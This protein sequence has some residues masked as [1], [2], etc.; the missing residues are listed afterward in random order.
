MGRW[1]EGVWVISPTVR[2]T[3]WGLM[4]VDGQRLGVRREAFDLLRH[5]EQQA[6]DHGAHWFGVALHEHD[7]CE[8]GRLEPK[9]ESLTSFTEYLDRRVLPSLSVS[10]PSDG[11]F[12]TNGAVKT[13][14][15]RRVLISR[16][17]R[18]AKI[19]LRSRREKFHRASMRSLASPSEKP[20]EMA[21]VDDRQIAVSRTSTSNA[22]AILLMSHAGQEGGRRLALRPFGLSSEQITSIGYSIWLYDRSGTGDSPPGSNFKLTPGN[23]DHR[24]DWM[25][26]LTMA[27]QTDLP[28]VAM[29]WSSGIVP[30]LAACG[31]GLLPD[32][33]IDGE[34]PADRWSL[35]PPPPS[36]EL[37]D[38]DLWSDRVWQGIEPLDLLVHFSGPYVRIQGAVDHVHGRM[39]VHGERMRARAESSGL[40]VPS[41]DVIPGRLDSYPG[42]ILKELERVMDIVKE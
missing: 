41:T 15:D 12:R 19:R 37:A 32:A 24:N 11:S 3:E 26:L 7:F 33:I 38:R 18:G 34:G 23:T 2:P 10:G 21:W 22:K 4:D 30:V 5:R 29:S 14:S 27:R 8:P 25:A 42:M 28:V 6:E 9:P 20:L 36:N 35:I 16:V 1:E 31:E 13:L 17:V 40:L 39:I